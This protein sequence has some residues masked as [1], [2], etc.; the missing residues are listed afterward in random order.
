MSLTPIRRVVTSVD[1]NQVGVVQI[2]EAIQF[3]ACIAEPNRN[4]YG[5]LNGLFR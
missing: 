3:K 1:T 4:A 5:Y 2:D